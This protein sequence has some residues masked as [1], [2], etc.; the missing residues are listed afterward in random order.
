MRRF[1]GTVS[2]GETPSVAAVTVLAFGPSPSYVV[3]N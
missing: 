2:G 1:T 3:L